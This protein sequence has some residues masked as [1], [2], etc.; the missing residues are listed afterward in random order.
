MA[1]AECEPDMLLPL[2]VFLYNSMAN[3]GDLRKEF[4]ETHARENK[5]R[6]VAFVF[7]ALRNA[8][9]DAESSDDSIEKDKIGQ[10]NEWFTNL[11]VLL[12]TNFDGTQQDYEITTASLF[13]LV[14]DS[15]EPVQKE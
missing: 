7:Q 13:R 10:V 1:N 2:L 4:V 12:Y 5:H 14:I 6:L 8:H 11:T 9:S 3:S 15:I